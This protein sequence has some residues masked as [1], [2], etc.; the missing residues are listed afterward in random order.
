M[1]TF[2]FD[3]IGFGGHN[4][5]NIQGMVLEATQIGFYSTGKGT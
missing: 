5:K 1:E 2:F 3:V 4:Q